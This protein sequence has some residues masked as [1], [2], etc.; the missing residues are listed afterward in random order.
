VPAGVRQ[1]LLLLLLV[2]I[3]LLLRA[4]AF[5]CGTVFFRLRLWL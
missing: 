1:L 5:L 4:L 2:A 3:G